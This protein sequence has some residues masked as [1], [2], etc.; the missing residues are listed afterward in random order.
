MG[1]ANCKDM[2]GISKGLLFNEI[3]MFQLWKLS[4]GVRRCFKCVQI[5]RGETDCVSGGMTKRGEVWMGGMVVAEDEKAGFWDC[6]WVSTP[7]AQP[8]RNSG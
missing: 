6:G 3:G 5:E 8:L 1:R 2:Y 7:R 4:H